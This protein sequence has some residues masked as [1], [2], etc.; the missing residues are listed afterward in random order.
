MSKLNKENLLS[1]ECSPTLQLWKINDKKA[2]RNGVHKSMYTVKE[3]VD[4]KKIVPINTKTYKVNSIY[5]GDWKENH[6]NGLGSQ[7]YPNKD[8][9]EGEWMDNKRSGKGTFWKFD[10]RGKYIRD[11]TGEWFD[12]KKHGLGTQFFHNGDKYDG[13]WVAGHMSGYGKMIYENNDIYVGSWSKGQRNGYGILIKSNGDLFEGHWINDKR[14]GEGCY[15]FKEKSKVIVGQ[16]VDDQPKT[17]IYADVSGEDEGYLANKKKMMSIPSLELE[18]QEILLK[19]LFDNIEQERKAYRIKNTYLV[20]LFDEE[21]FLMLQEKISVIAEN[22]IINASY[23]S[24]V[25]LKLDITNKE[26]DVNGVCVLLG[27]DPEQIDND[28]LYRIIAYI[29][30]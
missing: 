15:Y 28:N 19:N 5:K 17:A 20:D 24:G 21:T 10:K 14:E 2:D 16:W 13:C 22:K 23:V 30:N 9:Y 3:H 26:V 29:N 4:Q 11:Y 6:K 8:K 1:S 7:I 12:D 25:L 18:D 27:I